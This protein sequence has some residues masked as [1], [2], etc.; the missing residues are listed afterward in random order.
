MLKGNQPALKA[1]VDL[2]LEA[3][4]AAGA[5]PPPDH[6]TVCKGHGR[7]EQRAV[8]WVAAEELGAYLEH[9]HAWPGVRVCGRIRRSRWKADGSTEVEEHTW[10]SS[11]PPERATPEQVQAWL[12]GHWGIE[13]RVFRVRDVDY[14]EDRLHGRQVG[15]ALSALR[16]GALNLIRA[17]GYRYI[18]DA[19]R[20][21]SGCSPRFL[22]YLITS[23]S[24]L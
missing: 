20:D 11:A 3:Q 17:L 19:W 6:V 15:P 12:R 7:V 24:E 16:N 22:P 13:N 1:A 14:D 8:W 23:L 5:R 10:I 21:F 18:P 4:G 2:W 9:A